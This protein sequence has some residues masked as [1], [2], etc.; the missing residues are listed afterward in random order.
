MNLVLYII[1]IWDTQALLVAALELHTG[2]SR[3]QKSSWSLLPLVEPQSP[4]QSHRLP[5]C[6]LVAAKRPSVPVWFPNVSC[7]AAR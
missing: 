3:R 2:R 1:I 5:Q 6:L 4:T 7:L